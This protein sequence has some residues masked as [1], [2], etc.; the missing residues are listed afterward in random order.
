MTTPILQVEDASVTFKLPGG[1]IKAVDHVSLSIEPGETLA[2]V[3]ESGCGK[4][5]LARAVLG[6]QPLSG[7]SITLDGEAVTGT[8]RGLAAKVGMVWQ[9]PYASLDP[10]WT[11]AKSATEPLRLLKRPGSAD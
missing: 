3:G 5:T 7:G 8:V 11:V 9:D 6:L 4:T 1:E 2:V 10:R